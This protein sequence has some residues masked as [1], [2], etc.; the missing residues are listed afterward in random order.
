MTTCYIC[1]RDFGSASI[2]IHAPQCLKKWHIEN[3]KLPLSHRRS[4][5]QKPEI[6]L[7]GKS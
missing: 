5:P 7:I 6:V 3:A 1:G 2:E 4:E